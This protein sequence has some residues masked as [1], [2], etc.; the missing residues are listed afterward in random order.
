MDSRRLLKRRAFDHLL[1]VALLQLTERKEEREALAGRKALLQTKL[2]IMQRGSSFT[3]HTGAGENAKLQASLK[4][5]EKKLAT[6]GACEDVL[7]GNLA[8]ICDVLSKAEN[9][10]RLEDKVLCVDRMYVVHDNPSPSA[11]QIVFKDLHDSEGRQVTLQM[12][13][14]QAE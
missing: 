4:D 6:P 9:H 12:V 1:S 14:I 10:L 11:P 8:T 2:D 13:N 3:Q 7:A 5:I